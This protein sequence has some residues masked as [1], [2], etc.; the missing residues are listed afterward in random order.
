MYTCRIKSAPIRSRDT[1]DRP[2]HGSACPQLYDRPKKETARPTERNIESRPKNT[3]ERKGLTGSRVIY[4]LKGF[5]TAMQNN[6]YNSRKIQKFEA[7]GRSNQNATKWKKIFGNFWKKFPR[8]NDIRKFIL[9]FAI[10]AIECY[11]YCYY[12]TVTAF[13]ILRV[14]SRRLSIESNFRRDA[15]GRQEKFTYRDDKSRRN[16]ILS[17]CIV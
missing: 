14:E 3:S 5:W 15:E 2:G 12:V 1:L 7:Q 4:D 10:L 6:P 11:C 16:D 17:L 8:T 9:R 13:D